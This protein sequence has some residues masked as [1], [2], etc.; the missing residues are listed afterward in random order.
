MSLELWYLTEYASKIVPH[1]NGLSL[2][3]WCR[4]RVL[5]PNYKTYVTKLEIDRISSKQWHKVDVM[6]W[7]R[8]S[9]RARRH[10]DNKEEKKRERTE[11]ETG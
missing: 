4:C 6:P 11:R 3:L 1:L 7:F 2:K 8:G 10:T 9:D 5:L